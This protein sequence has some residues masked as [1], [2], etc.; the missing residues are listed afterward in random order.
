MRRLPIALMALLGLLLASCTQRECNI[1]GTLEGGADGDTLLLIT[2]QEGGIPFDTIYVKGGQFAYTMAVDS[3]TLCFIQ[4]MRDGS[5][6]LPF[7]LEPGE[8]IITMK[9]DPS[10][11]SIRG[12]HLNEEFQQ[13]NTAANDFQKEMDQ[14]MA[15]SDTSEQAQKALQAK[16]ME[17]SQHLAAR[18]YETAE[19]NIDNELGYLLVT[20]PAMLSEEQVLTLINKMPLQ[21]RNRRQIK[22]MEQFLKTAASGTPSAEGTKMPDFSASTPE[23]KPLSAMSVVSANDLTII[24][25]WASWCG[26]CMREMP[27]MVE[28][29]Q[30]Y[31]DKGLG[32]LG[33]SLDTDKD[34]WQAAI[35]ET[36]ASWP[37]ISELTRNS[38]IAQ[39]FGVQAIPFTLVVDREGNVLASGLT[40]NDLEDFVRNNLPK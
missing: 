23:G 30:L 4:P 26:P 12:T 20:N 7:F 16:A 25:F 2:D 38:Q 21:M 22:E 11:S 13:L 9:K 18:F 3:A 14:L 15:N 34:A 29:Y 28:I 33:V 10:L 24:D 8:I 1:S 17:A 40:G 5:Y 39:Q 35:K 6:I 37:Q 27:H 36:G 31:K 32:I 19:K